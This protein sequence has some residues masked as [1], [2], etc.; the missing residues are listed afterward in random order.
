MLNS[1]VIPH[2]TL[3]VL[4]SM[5]FCIFLSLL[6]PTCRKSRF[7]STSVDSPAARCLMIITHSHSPGFCRRQCLWSVFIDLVEPVAHVLEALGV[8][9]V[10][11][12]LMRGSTVVVMNCENS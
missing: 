4:V 2:H 6:L 9:H 12:D 3:P 10:V 1:R 11:D 8:R 5:T 7:I